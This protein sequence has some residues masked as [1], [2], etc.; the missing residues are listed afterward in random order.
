MFPKEYLETLRESEH[1]KCY[2][3]ILK[4][5][6]TSLVITPYYFEVNVSKY[7]SPDRIKVGGKV[8]IN[9]PPDKPK[10]ESSELTNKGNI[11]KA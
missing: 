4:D 8:Y 9:V 5:E 10:E 6:N 1:N 11:I 2:F 3:T 7:D